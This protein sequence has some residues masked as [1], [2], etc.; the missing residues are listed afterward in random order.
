METR[1]T[2]TREGLA[3]RPSP[4]GQE[5]IAH[6]VVGGYGNPPYN[7]TRGARSKTFVYQAV[8]VYGNPPYNDDARAQRP[9]WAGA[10]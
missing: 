6:R 10:R 9:H 2:A 1:P 4:I 7:D 5:T 8:G 3:R